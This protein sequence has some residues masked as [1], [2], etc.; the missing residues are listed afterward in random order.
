MKSVS[1]FFMLSLS[2]V[3]LAAANW[4]VVAEASNC[5]VKFKV[6]AK[7]GEKFVYVDDGVNKTKL[8]SVDGDIYKDD[9]AKSTV[10][11]NQNSNG[12]RL[13]FI[14]PS[15]VEGNPPKLDIT[16]NGI[17]DYCKLSLKK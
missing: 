17:K 15:A 13:T 14:Q 7:E 8:F 6:L 1:F 10:Y 4:K 2:S 9:H 5:D 11:Q 3:S 12:R 16:Q